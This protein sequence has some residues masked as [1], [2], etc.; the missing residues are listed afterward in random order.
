[1]ATLGASGEPTNDDSENT[2]SQASV[3][4]INTVVVSEPNASTGELNSVVSVIDIVFAIISIG[5]YV[6]DQ[7]S[8]IWLAYVYYISGNPRWC[9]YTLTVIVVPTVIV[10][11][12]SLSWY[13]SDYQHEQKRK[14]KKTSLLHWIVRAVFWL[15]HISRLIRYVTRQAGQLADTLS[16]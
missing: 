8:D 14:E 9:M 13:I 3:R 2:S 1:M 7:G 15:L 4:D 12:L 6:L 11:M 10:N 16:L 5:L